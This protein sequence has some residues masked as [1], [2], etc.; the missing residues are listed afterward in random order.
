MKFSIEYK[1]TVRV[2]KYETL[3]IGIVNEFDDSS[4]GYNKAYMQTRDQVDYHIETELERLR[5]EIDK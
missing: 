4:I 3:T 2:Q 5:K 1:R